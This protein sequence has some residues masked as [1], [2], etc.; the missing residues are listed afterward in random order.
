MP[1]M[2]NRKDRWDRPSEAYLREIRKIPVL[3]AEEERD[4]VRRAKQ[5]DAAAR[6]HLVR[7]NLRLVTYIAWRFTGRGLPVEDL[8]GE[9]NLG[10]LRAASDFDPAR[11]F[12][13]STYAVC[14]IK[15]AIRR[16]L[17]YT[18]RTIH[19]PVHIVERLNSWRQT[20][21]QLAGELGRAPA[22]EDVAERM[23]LP[24]KHVPALQEA[25]RLDS[26]RPHGH[27][28]HRLSSI[29]DSVPDRRTEVPHNGLSVAEVQGQVQ[30][31]LDQLRPRH[32]A[33]LRL[34]FGLSGTEPKSLR[35]IGQEMGITHERVRQI[36]RSALASLR[37]WLEEN[38]QASLTRAGRRAV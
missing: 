28:S 7:A 11:G 20:S 2:Q 36:E 15:Q 16:A 26:H 34:R 29:A 24:G 23:N 6:D 10:L 22:P 8:I 17:R 3:S 33:V 12:R 38:P 13:F 14:W 30:G 35:A 27:F 37:S 4:I 1:L 5:G 18:T 9:G 32:A 21:A 19:I 25:L 31:L